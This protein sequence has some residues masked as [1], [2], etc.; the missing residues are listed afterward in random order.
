[1]FAA[2]WLSNFIFYG[3]IEDAKECFSAAFQTHQFKNILKQKNIKMF[4]T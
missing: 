1:M 2:T 4:D 3:A